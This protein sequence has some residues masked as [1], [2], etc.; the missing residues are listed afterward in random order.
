MCTSIAI[1]IDLGFISAGGGIFYLQ[2]H[3]CFADR[4]FP[5]L[6]HDPTTSQVLWL[7]VF[8]SAP[9]GLVFSI[10]GLLRRSRPPFGGSRVP[11]VVFS[12]NLLAGTLSL[13]T[14]VTALLFSAGST[15]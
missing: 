1:A 5:S 14:L 12:I 13:L 8:A 9:V 10:I 3:F 15:F 7:L 6:C 4:Y 11:V 2:N